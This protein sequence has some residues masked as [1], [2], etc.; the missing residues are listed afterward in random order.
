MAIAIVTGSGGLIG[1]ESVRALRRGRLRRGRDRERHARAL[2]RRRGVDAP[3]HAS[4]W[5]SALRRLPL[6]SS[7]TSAT[8]TASSG[9]FAEHARE[10]ELVVHTAAQPS[11][12]WAATD[13]HDRLR[14]QRQRHAQPARGGARRTRPTRRSS[15]PRRTRSTATGR[16]A[17]RSSSSRRGSS[18]PSDH[19]YYG[20]IDTTMSIDRSTALAVR[21]LEGRRRPAGA[22]VRALLRHA[23]GLLPR[24]LPDRPAARRR[25]AAR[26]PLLPDALHG[27]R[28]AATRSSATAA[29]RCATTSTR[30]RRA[31]VRGVPRA[32]RG[33]RRSTTSAAGARSNCSMLEAIALCERDRRAARSTGRCATRRA[34]A[35]TAGGSAT[36]ARS[37]ADY[38]GW[39]L[40]ATTSRRSCARSTT[41]TSSAGAR[42]RREALGR[43]PGPQRGGVD[44]RDAAARSPRALDARRHRL[45]DPRRRRRAARDGTAARRRARW[46][47]RNPRVRC[48]RSPYPRRLRLRRA[49]RARALRR[50]TRSRS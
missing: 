45:R 3:R 36:S 15:S 11:H 28:R 33:R 1:S 26:L 21:R 12:D 27:H 42:R 13:P 37:E 20:G 9:V 49:R 44:R 30:R 22:G 16:T 18:C 19:R 14:R 40:D 46:R 29:S 4:G 48:M 38:P 47:P 17:C 5:S 6:A 34:S 8:P 50:A 23:D 2:L 24:R 10:I 31:R 25:A 35:T 41:R 7:S 43:H 32:T 39:E